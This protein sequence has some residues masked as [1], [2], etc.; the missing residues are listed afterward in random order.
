MPA[1]SVTSVTS[2]RATVARVA[3]LLI[4]CVATLSNLG[5]DPNTTDVAMR[6]HRALGLTVH[7]NDLVD[8]ARN[9]VLFAGLGAVWLATTR[10]T[11][12]L[13]VV[14]RVTAIG[15]VLSFGVEVLQLFSP[16]RNASILDVITD[17]LGT[18][19]GALGTVFAFEAVK[20]RVGKRSYVGIP[21]FVFAVSYGAAI[22]MEAFFPLLRQDMLPSVSS[23]VGDRLAQAWAAVDAHS[24]TRFPLTDIAIFF[25]LGLFA[26]A[27]AAE[28]GVPFAVS[29]PTV[30]IV[31]G[32][33]LAIVELLHGIALVPIV[34]GAIIIHV[35]ALAIGSA[36]APRLLKAFGKRLH[37]RGRPRLLAAA[38]AVEIMVWSWRP[39][40]LD[41][42]AQ[43]MAAQFSVVH[44]IPLRALASRM[45]L[46]SVTDVIAQFVL[47]LPL[48]ALL[49]VW[50][51]RRRGA[52]RGLLPVLYLSVVLELGKIVVADRFM[53][54]TH[55]LIQCAG[56]AI[57]WLL[58]HRAGFKVNGEL[59]G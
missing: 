56:A 50:P 35:A 51:L 39:F 55:I 28:L 58:I 16:I 24:M 41:V 34:P 54:V 47:F 9:L 2:T 59:L 11:S 38:Y 26:V 12:P 57:G 27:A 30:A 8:G 3:Y 4:I 40:R 13:R 14:A 23:G 36:L 29:W 32:A 33:L 6:V 22:L 7:M 46:F 20:A 5:F 31:G 52:L 17:T 10:T 53:D 37:Q 44:L 15:F 1:T 43:G 25:P 48:G 45:D 49:A 42:D 19:A 18:L 21:A